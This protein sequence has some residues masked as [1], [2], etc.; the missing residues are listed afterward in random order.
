MRI[1]FDEY[2]LK[3]ESME[4]ELDDLAS[5]LGLAQLQSEVTRLEELAAKEGFWDDLAASQKVLQ[6]TKQ[7]KHK[8][9]RFE[10]LHAR[11]EDA[12]TLVRRR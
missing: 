1:E 3:L 9:E 12:C 2:R 6:K 10:A 7:A 8:I 11:W 5:A 4:Q